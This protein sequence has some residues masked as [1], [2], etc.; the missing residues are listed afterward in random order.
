[1][2]VLACERHDVDVE[3][4]RSGRSL[5]R[6]ERA[7]LQR[8]ADTPFRDVRA[9]LDGLPPRLTLIVRWGKDVIPETGENGAAG[10]PGKVKEIGIDAAVEWQNSPV[11]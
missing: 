7:E 5:S 2:V 6:V 3:L 1:M 8:I 4:P 9:Q 10:Y 11:Y